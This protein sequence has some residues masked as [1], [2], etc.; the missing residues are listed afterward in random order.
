MIGGEVAELAVGP[1]DDGLGD[2]A[3]GGGNALDGRAQLLSQR[4]LVADSDQRR[5]LDAGNEARRIEVGVLAVIVDEGA[6]GDAR[7]RTM[8]EAY[9]LHQHIRLILGDMALRFGERRL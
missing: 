2:M 9:I 1:G 5:L 4:I 7:L 6:G 8:E 3:G